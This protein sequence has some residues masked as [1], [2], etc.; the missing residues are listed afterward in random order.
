MMMISND[1]DDEDNDE[2]NGG[3]RICQFKVGEDH[4]D[5]EERDPV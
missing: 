4:S 3:C 2:T 1:D 5:C